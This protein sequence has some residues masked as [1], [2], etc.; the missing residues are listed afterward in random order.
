MCV[1][2]KEDMKRDNLREAVAE[3]GGEDEDL[4]FTSPTSPLGSP[5][6]E[7]DRQAVRFVT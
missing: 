1:I 4:S 7:L 5:D 6:G 3:E 2:G